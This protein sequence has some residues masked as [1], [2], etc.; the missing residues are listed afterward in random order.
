MSFS[1]RLMSIVEYIIR[2]P[3]DK[4]HG[5]TATPYIFIANI[6]IYKGVRISRRMIRGSV[7]DT[8]KC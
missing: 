7:G 4:R 5:E 2:G 6:N 3:H 8:T 1:N